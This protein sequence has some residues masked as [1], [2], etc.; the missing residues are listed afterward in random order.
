[1]KDAMKNAHRLTIFGALALPFAIA[2]VSNA[3]CKKEEEP[4][5]PPAPAPAP[6][7]AEPLVV[8]PEEDAGSDAAEDADADAGKVVKGPAVDSTGIRACCAAL[9]GNAKSAPP[10][11]VMVYNM[12]AAVCDGLVNNPQGRAAL[13]QVRAALR[14]A[15]MPAACQ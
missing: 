15:S 3:G 12:A 11:Q 2:L 6:A 1:M 9:R 4:P 13:G 8:A 14:G 10:D 5:P 7:P